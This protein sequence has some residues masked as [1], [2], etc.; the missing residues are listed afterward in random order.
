MQCA[1]NKK[2]AE[3]ICSLNTFQLLQFAN[4]RFEAVCDV[5]LQKKEKNQQKEET[6]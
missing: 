2:H 1:L 6:S 5:T 3:E 4:Y